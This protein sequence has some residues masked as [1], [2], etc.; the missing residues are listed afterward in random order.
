MENTV[1]LDIV[2]ESVCQLQDDPSFNFPSKPRATTGEE[3]ECI[4]AW[5][6]QQADR[7]RAKDEAEERGKQEMR[8]KA[9]R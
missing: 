8:E 3:P 6:R 1:Y 2:N 7:I 9:R 4:V 5:R